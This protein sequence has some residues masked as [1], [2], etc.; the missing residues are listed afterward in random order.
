MKVFLCEFI[1]PE[2]K[3]YLERNAEIISDW[4]NINE[5]D[6]I[7]NRNLQ[8][9][10]EIMDKAYN[11]K[12][13]AIHG[14]G[15]DG[16]DMGEAKKRGIHVFSTPHQNA[17]SVAEMI[18]GL[19]L[20]LT[21][22]ISLAGKLIGKGKKIDNAPSELKGIELRGK[23]FGLIGVGDIAIRASKIMKYGFGMKVIGFSRS[24]TKEKAKDIDIGYC[25]SIDEVLKS[26]DIVNIGVSLNNSTVNMINNEKIKLMKRTSYLINTSRGKVIDEKALYNALKNNEIAGAACDVFVNEPPTL[27]NPL[28]SLDNF[29]ATPHIG[30]NT[31]EALYRVGMSVV[32]GILERVK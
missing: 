20:S 28:L 11:L 22:K 8:I 5:V 9:T 14:T 32:K 18:V 19:I 4:N 23:T 25:S 17:D 13:I 12:V 16:V 3:K 26:S 15:M 29:I 10:K 2:A 24:L 1:H 7:I 27:D 31:D 30:A 21:R 6:A